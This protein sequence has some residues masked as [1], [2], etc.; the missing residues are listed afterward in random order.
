MPKGWYPDPVTPGLQ[1]YWDGI[2][3]TDTTHVP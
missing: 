3:W 1:R 2:A